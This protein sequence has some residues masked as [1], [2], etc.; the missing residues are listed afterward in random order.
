MA[1][2]QKQND[3]DVDGEEKQGEEKQQ[4]ADND[5]WIVKG[6]AGLS[7]HPDDGILAF[8]CSNSI[9]PWTDCTTNC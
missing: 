3:M 7:I 9:R 2:E 6:D 1:E 5:S 8:G 4:E